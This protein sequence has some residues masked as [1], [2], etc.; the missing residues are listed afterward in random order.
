VNQHLAGIRPRVHTA[1]CC[2]PLL[3]GRHLGVAPLIYQYGDQVITQRER[4]A[5]EAKYA[6]RSPTGAMCGRPGVD[7][8][9]RSLTT[10]EPPKEYLCFQR[11][12][13][14]MGDLS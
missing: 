8:T 14:D 3:C 11:S 1:T 4:Q 12:G 5:P 13:V 9:T 7:S 10:N 2:V 6:W